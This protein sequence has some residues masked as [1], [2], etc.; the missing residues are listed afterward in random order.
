MALRN[1]VADV[2]FLVIDPED[3]YRALCAEVGGQSVRL[4]SSSPH[5][6]NPFELPGSPEDV[7]RPVDGSAPVDVL[8]EKVAELLGLLQIIVS[9][10][11]T[12]LRTAERAMLD[13]AL[14]Q[15]YAAAHIT[16]DPATHDRPP[17]LL[18]DLHAVLRETPGAL[19]EDLAARLSRFIDGSLGSGMLAGP[20]NVALDRHLVVFNIRD[21]EEELRPLAMHVL[22]GF[23]WNRVRRKRRPRLLVID[24][25]WSLLRYA[26][27]G[28]FVSAMA[29]RAR[30]YYL[31]L[32]IISQDVAD[33][34][35]SPHGRAV[36]VNSAMKLL[37]KQDAS[38]IEA[39]QVAFRLTTDER[40]QLLGADKGE[41]LLFVRGSHVPLL[42]EGSRA[43]HLLATTAPRELAELVLDAR[44]SAPATNGNIRRPGFGVMLETPP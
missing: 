38:T 41:G 34:L 12:E 24:E 37:L 35:G 40:Q 36:L 32:V 30:K 19:A 28:A 3:E 17:P 39:V 13:R 14:F 6:L 15:T 11:G 33:V 22:A 25:A 23:V 18:R 42:I 29:R 9:D 16:R 5:R 20:T 2:D 44:P 43:E 8:A 21:L 26:D 1:L 27:G 7:A 4:A 10:A 31:G